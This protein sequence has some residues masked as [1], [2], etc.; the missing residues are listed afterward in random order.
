MDEDENEMKGREES[1]LPNS[2]NNTINMKR[3]NPNLSVVY[4]S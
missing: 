3:N 1:T 2:A 4:K